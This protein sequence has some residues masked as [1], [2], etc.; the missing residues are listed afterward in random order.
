MTGKKFQFSIPVKVE[1]EE[2]KEAKKFV[3]ECLRNNKGYTGNITSAINKIIKDSIN[4]WPHAPSTF[5]DRIY[6]KLNLNTDGSQ[7]SSGGYVKDDAK[8]QNALTKRTGRKL[9]GEENTD[10]AWIELQLLLTPQEKLFY[11]KRINDYK[12]DFGLNDSS[13]IPIVKQIVV[14]EIIQARAQSEVLKASRGEDAN[15]D[16]VK[17]LSQSNERLQKAQTSL[18]ITGA[19]RKQE[20]TSADG[21]IGQLAKKYSETLLEYQDLEDK[22]AAE[23][24]VVL[25]RKYVRGEMTQTQFS[26][27]TN[28]T[29]GKSLSLDDGKEL[30]EEYISRGILEKDKVSLDLDNFGRNTEKLEDFKYDHILSHLES[31]NDEEKLLEEDNE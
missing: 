2:L 15:F 8:I 14:E 4:G 24:L 19:Q 29:F 22:W 7:K 31:L 6:S 16:V 18:G 17:I 21:T 28:L 10:E 23:E 25:L 27:L 13:D 11:E 3:R 30:F 5:K 9:V 1:Q 26:V 12:D 20:K